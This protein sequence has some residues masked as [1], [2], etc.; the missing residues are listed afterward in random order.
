MKITRF[1]ILFLCGIM[2]QI[3][4]AFAQIQL[5]AAENFYGEVAQELGGDQ[6]AVTSIMQNPEQDPHL[7]T[8]SPTIARAIAKADIVV[9]NGAD[10]DDWMVKLLSASSKKT[11]TLVI[12]EL[13][14]AKKGENPHIWYIPTTMSH[15][16]EALSKKLIE[17]DPSH[18]D[19]YAQRLQ[20]FQQKQ[21]ALQNTVARLK[22]KTNGVM[23]TATEPV[24]NWMAEALGLQMRNLA[25]QWSVE[26]E[27]SPSPSAVKAMLDDLKNHT[28]RVL[29]YNAQ[30]TSPLVTQIK[31]AAE[32]NHIPVIGVTET[33]PPGVRYHQWMA[34]QL[35]DLEKVIIK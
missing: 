30:V 11:Y 9:Y 28:V 34:Q 18:K 6:V 14:G 10:Y 12:A 19:D 15:Y 3:P 5:V 16:A 35:R 33:Q 27:A 26:N 24:F 31:E 20:Q 32:K 2:Y 7:F 21:T 4:A 25:F 13:I 23:V 22:Q 29:F 1:F 8:A 17:L